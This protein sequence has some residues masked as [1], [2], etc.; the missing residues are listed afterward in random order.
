MEKAGP[1]RT[2]LLLLRA[3]AA[4]AGRGL[5]LL[6]SKREALVREFFKIM[7]RAVSNRDLFQETFQG[8]V[9]AM[10]VALGLEGRA[11]LES[12]SFA[13]RRDIPIE[14]TEK[15]VWGVRFP[16]IHYRSVVRSSDARGYA[17][18]SVSS[19]ANAAAR[20]FEKTLDAV[21]RIISVEMRL[22]KIGAEI[23]RTTRRINA[24]SEV[25]LPD[26]KRRMRSIRFALEEREREETF[27]IKRFKKRSRG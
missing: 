5:D 7:D 22:K 26:L 15:N 14:L 9:N 24:L 18:S 1:T 6:R 13:A 21:L 8:A 10:T 20:E 25:I 16:D 4:S 23:K 11:G 12:A 19:H 17:L 2:H 27:R 3:R